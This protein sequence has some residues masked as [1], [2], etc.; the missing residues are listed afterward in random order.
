M[1]W[2]EVCYAYALALLQGNIADAVRI[3]IAHPDKSDALSEAGR[4]RYYLAHMNGGVL[5]PPVST[6]DDI[7]NCNEAP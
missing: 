5:P 2:D 6:K 7:R 1:V 4:R 3:R